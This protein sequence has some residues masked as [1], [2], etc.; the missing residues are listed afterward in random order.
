ML[1]KG[2][3]TQQKQQT[4][5]SMWAGKAKLKEKDTQNEDERESDDDPEM[6]DDSRSKLTC[7]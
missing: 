3:K 4:L 6:M 7:I 2:K 1:P 5:F